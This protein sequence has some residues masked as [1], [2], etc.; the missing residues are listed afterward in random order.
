ML[1]AVRVPKEM[2]RLLAD[3]HCRVMVEL[4]VMVLSMEVLVH[5]L[6]LVTV[7]AAASRSLDFAAIMHVHLT[8]VVATLEQQDWVHD[9][10]NHLRWSYLVHGWD[11]YLV[12]LDR[13]LLVALVMQYWR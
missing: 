1:V 4:V 8:A 12:A 11:E 6:V 5:Q 7:V 13:T 9:E 3:E 10:R 2:R